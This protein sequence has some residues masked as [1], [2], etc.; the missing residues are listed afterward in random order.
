MR[1]WIAGFGHNRPVEMSVTVEGR[2]F[3]LPSA[4]WSP[5]SDVMKRFP[6]AGLETGFLVAILLDGHGLPPRLPIEGTATF[7]HGSGVLENIGP[8]T[9]F[10]A[11]ADG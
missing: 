7:G 2:S 5:R 10:G 3:V 11:K 4:R 1:G 6:S 9:W 8:E